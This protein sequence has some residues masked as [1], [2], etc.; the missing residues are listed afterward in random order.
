MKPIPELL[1]FVLIS[2]ITCLMWLPYVLARV[3]IQGLTAA[4][5]NPAEWRAQSPQWAIRARMA[6]A[7]A[8]ENLA[9]FAPL[10]LAA[11]IL[12]ISTG[13]TMFASKLFLGA[14]VVHFAVYVAGIPIIRTLAF[15][16]GVAAT[17]IFAF[18]LIS[19]LT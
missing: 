16:A 13:A 5:G 1:P 8:I 4:L 12:G 2:L 19:Q 9:V 18:T 14:R 15:L 6:H 7:N 3:R 11:A 17:L 10:V